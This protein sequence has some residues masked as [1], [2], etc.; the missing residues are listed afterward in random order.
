MICIYVYVALCIFMCNCDEERR[1][2]KYHHVFLLE[3]RSIEKNH[4]WGRGG[5]YKLV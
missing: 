4:N 2:K 1:K 3:K 5:L